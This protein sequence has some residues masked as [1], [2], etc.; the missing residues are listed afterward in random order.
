MEYRKI[1]KSDLSVSK[2]SMGTWAMGG[3]FFGPIAEKDAI[4]AIHA[5]LDNGINLIDTAPC[6]GRGV[7]EKVVGKALK[8]K[9]GKYLIATKCGVICHSQDGDL[10]KHILDPMMVEM[11]IDASLKRLGVDC[12]DLYQLHYPDE[13]TPIE[14]TMATLHKLQEAGK[15]RYIGVSNFS[16]EQLKA[17]C[18]CADV[19]SMQ[20][21]YSYLDREYDHLGMEY[22]LENNIGVL[23]FGSLHGGMLS[24]KYQTLP[25]PSPLERRWTFYSAF[26]QPGFE[27]AKVLMDKVRPI[28][29]KYGCPLAHIMMGW[30]AARAGI[31]TALVGIKN[32]AQAEDMARAC[33]LELSAEDIAFMNDAYDQVERES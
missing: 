9:S 20:T 5:A 21:R 24:G 29:E 4:S 8:G 26:T 31:T 17:A 28:A 16:E 19:V 12:I 1:G 18:A 13:L 23:S 27:K 6:Y 32:V 2:I 11:E 25:T 14:D 7:S 33:A 30:V 22:C 3:D 15:I 10:F